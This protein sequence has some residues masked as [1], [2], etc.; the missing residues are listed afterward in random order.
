M[1]IYKITVSLTVTFI[2]IVRGMISVM[3]L[4]S[5]LNNYFGM[6]ALVQACIL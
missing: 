2:C 3:A 6:G 5:D 4:V 1:V